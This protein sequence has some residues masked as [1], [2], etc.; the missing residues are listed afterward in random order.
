MEAVKDIALTEGRDGS[1]TVHRA[2]CP[3]VRTLAELGF[4][5]ATLLGIQNDIPD[6]LERHSCLEEVERA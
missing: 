1:V 6:D 4:P 3:D 5:V 2:D